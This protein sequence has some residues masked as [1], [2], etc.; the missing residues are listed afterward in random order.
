MTSARSAGA[1]ASPRV[2][3]PQTVP[4][5]AGGQTPPSRARAKRTRSAADIGDDRPSPATS[6]SKRKAPAAERARVDDTIVI[7]NLT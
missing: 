1:T 2:A 6:T 4:S 3:S 5:A 7:G